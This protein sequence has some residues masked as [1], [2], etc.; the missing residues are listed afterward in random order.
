MQHSTELVFS[1][2][3][4][5]FMSNR[6]IAVGSVFYLRTKCKEQANSISIWI[7]FF[8]AYSFIIISSQIDQFCYICGD[9]TLNAQSILFLRKELGLYSGCKVDDQDKIFCHT[10]SR[11][12]TGWIWGT[13]KYMRF[14]KPI[15]WQERQTHIDDFTKILELFRER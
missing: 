12:L 10:C 14:G 7:Q 13:Q 6:L 5:R 3:Q 15:I 1:M 9:M 8:F 11:I 2:F 4:N